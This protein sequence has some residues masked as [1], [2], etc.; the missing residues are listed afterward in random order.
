MRYCNSG[1]ASI[2]RCDVAVVSTDGGRF[3]VK[4][5][6]SEIARELNSLGAVSPR[7]LKRNIMVPFSSITVKYLLGLTKV[8]DCKEEKDW[9]ALEK[10]LEEIAGFGSDASYPKIKL[11]KES[12][13]DHILSTLSDRNCFL[14]HRKFR[15]FDCLKHANKTM[16]YI[17]YNLVKTRI[18]RKKKEIF[19]I[20]MVVIDKNVDVEFYRLPVEELAELL[21]NDDVNVE[22]EVQMVEVID[23]WISADSTNREIFRPMLMTTIRLSGLSEET[24]R[25]FSNFHLSM[26][27]PRKTRDIL[28][29]VG[30]WLHRQACD[31]IEWF[32]PEN[33]EWKVSQQKLPMAIAYHGA[34]IVN[35]TLYVFG[36]SNGIRT[37]CE[38]WKLSMETCQWEKCDNML[39]PRNY[40]SNSSVV[41]DGKIYVFGGQN[42]REISRVG[43][44]SRTGEVYDPKTDRWTATGGL[45]DMRSDCAAAVFDNQIY[46]CGGFNGDQILSSVEVYNPIEQTTSGLKELQVES[47]EVKGWG[48][49]IWV[50]GETKGTCMK[51]IYPKLEC[52]GTKAFKFSDNTLIKKEG[53]HWGPNEPNGFGKEQNCVYIMITKNETD[54]RYGKLDDYLC[55]AN[56]T[57]LK[58]GV[59]CRKEP[60]LE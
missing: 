37:R 59:L 43:S 25:M 10:S 29:T 15:Q 8:S 53:Y 22:K 36:G 38:T 60:L 16:K 4:L 5:V 55:N 3:E 41:F 21:E 34:A 26:R 48:W 23:R 20:R 1:L 40:I 11:I 14:I 6:E 50:D 31:R 57:F 33:N 45:H 2:E 24:T 19:Q 35:G 49:G 7:S 12:F 17:L 52:N 58:R 18:V 47:E 46:V 27:K 56:D 13:C 44:R 39:E 51:T 30:G 28:I 54:S 9:F 32:D 42:W